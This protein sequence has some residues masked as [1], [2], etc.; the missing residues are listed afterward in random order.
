MAGTKGILIFLS[1]TLTPRLPKGELL[2]YSEV[3]SELKLPLKPRLSLC[4]SRTE[5]SRGLFLFSCLWSPHEVQ[6]CR[7]TESTGSTRLINVDYKG[8]ETCQPV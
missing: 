2:W 8:T 6:Q 7:V 3:T 5:G 4:E 1:P